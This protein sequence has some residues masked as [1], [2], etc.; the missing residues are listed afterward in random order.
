MNLIGAGDLI[1]KSWSIYWSN[2]G[3]LLG[4]AIWM[5]VPLAALTIINL[6]PQTYLILSVALSAAVFVGNVIIGL[7]V[8]V[9]LVQALAKRY[10]NEDVNTRILY[11]KAWSKIG[12]LF[13]VS[14][15]VGLAVF[16][17]T[18]LFIIPGIIF[19]VW[20]FFAS[21]IAILENVRGTKALSESKKLVSGM[22]WS[23]FWRFLASYV[24]YGA[25]FLVVMWLVI[26]LGSMITGQVQEM[27]TATTPPLWQ[28]LA[29]NIINILVTPLFVAIGAILYLELKKI[30]GIKAIS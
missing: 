26:F 25:L 15:L 1:R 10:Q 30:K 4:I 19:A 27:A 22:W 16:G 11:S 14:I 28:S 24:V 18:L 8:N 7:W 20:F 17:G 29:T 2:L 23:V 5:L 3:L 21:Y 12:P 6:I 13:W 9:C